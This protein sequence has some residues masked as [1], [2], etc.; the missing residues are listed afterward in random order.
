M[1]YF[2]D[3]I[4]ISAPGSSLPVTA[5]QTRIMAT[6]IL[7]ASAIVTGGSCG[8]GVAVGNGLSLISWSIS[9]CLVAI[10]SSRASA[11][12]IEGW[13]IHHSAR[14]PLALIAAAQI[15]CDFDN[16]RYRTLFAS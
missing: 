10:I 16:R 1:S 5:D 2:A 4:A 6:P 9:N 3:K 15:R 13:S 8:G 12:K 11:Y 7:I 14:N